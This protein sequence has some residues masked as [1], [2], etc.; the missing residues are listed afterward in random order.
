MVRTPSFD[1]NGIKRGAWSE[2][3]DNKLRAFVQKN[4]HPNWRLLPSAAGL[5]RCGKSCRLRWVNYLQP[6]LKKGIFT[7]EEEDLI[8]KLHNQIGNKWSVMAENLPGRTDNDIKN[9]WHAHIKKRSNRSKEP[10]HQEETTIFDAPSSSEINGHDE[11]FDWTTILYDLPPIVPEFELC[12]YDTPTFSDSSHDQPCIKD[13]LFEFGLCPNDVST[14]SDSSEGGIT[15]RSDST[16]SDGSFWSE[17][18]YG[19]DTVDMVLWQ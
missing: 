19:D 1:S 16:E 2:D 10:N 13:G 8:I 18:A 9:H 7:K 3:E 14:F 11:F 5:K 12:H 4:G 15:S 17:Y 6:G